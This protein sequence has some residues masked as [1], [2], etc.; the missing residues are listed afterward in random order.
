MPWGHAPS[1]GSRAGSVLPLQLLEAP[2]V[3]GCVAASPS[4]SSSV[5]RPHLRLLCVSLMK[6]HLSLGLWPTQIS[7]DDLILRPS[8]I[9]TKSFSPHKVPFTGSGVRTWTPFWG[10]HSAHCRSSLSQRGPGPSR[11]PQPPHPWA[12]FPW[13]GCAWLGVTEGPWRESRGSV[14]SEGGAG[15][16]ARHAWAHP[17]GSLA[18]RGP[19]ASSS[20]TPLCC[21][22][23]SGTLGACGPCWEGLLV[24]SIS[25]QLRSGFQRQPDPERAGA[26]GRV[27]GGRMGGP[28]PVG[29]PEATPVREPGSGRLTD[30][31][32]EALKRT[33]R[34]P[35]RGARRAPWQ[36]SSRGAL[37][38]AARSS[39]S[40][41]VRAA[42][43]ATVQVGVLVGVPR[44]TQL[45]VNSAGFL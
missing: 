14:P 12:S 5:P 37:G 11:S 16:G 42:P 38:W 22:G 18:P 28:E 23:R 1:R 8:I 10:H 19:P 29:A 3:P 17:A 26:A 9:F 32:R 13:H 25:M 30:P 20:Q 34:G 35:R 39:C 44:V 45:F 24:G 4:L 7:Q 2:G 21:H 27:D 33:G 31:L 43:G 36:A 6:G 41:A 15:V 40:G